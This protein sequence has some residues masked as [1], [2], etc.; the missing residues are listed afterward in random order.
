MPTLKNIITGSTILGFVLVLNACVVA[1]GPHG[2][3]SEPHNHSSLVY[4][5][6]YP[7]YGVYYHPVDHY[8]YYQIGGIWRRDSRLPA[9]WVLSSEPRVRM[10]LSGIPYK[11]YSDH[12]RYYPPRRVVNVVTPD[13]PHNGDR[14][15]HQHRPDRD[16]RHGSDGS[17]QHRPDMDRK[18]GGNMFIPH[19]KEKTVYDKRQRMEKSDKAGSFKGDN[20]SPLK[21]LKKGSS[22]SGTKAQEN[23]K[24]KTQSKGSSEKTKPGKGNVKGKYKK[25]DDE[26]G[27]G[28]QT[29]SEK[30]K[31]EDQRK[32]WYKER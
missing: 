23:S 3:Y 30:G 12:R 26:G 16:G 15:D 6:Y 9:G 13:R 2:Y 10:Q 1:P 19:T 18:D 25:D 31:N 27:D 24:V 14:H 28:K 11:R 32:D 17:P 22:Y 7:N 5:Y 4:W 29:G 21:E 20:K 8:Y